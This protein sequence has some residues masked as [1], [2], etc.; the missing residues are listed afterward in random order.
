MS[1]NLYKSKYTSIK[2]RCTSTA[3]SERDPHV[4]L[5]EKQDREELKEAVGRTT[6]VLTAIVLCLSQSYVNRFSEPFVRVHTDS[7]FSQQQVPDHCKIYMFLVFPI[8]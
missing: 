4:V 6:S 1:L 2:P 8:F 3:E 7:N 5:C